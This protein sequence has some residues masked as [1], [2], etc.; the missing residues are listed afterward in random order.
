MG[1]VERLRGD[2]CD[3]GILR[4]F[5]WPHGNGFEGWAAVVKGVFFLKIGEMFFDICGIPVR[6]SRGISR[7][8][9]IQRMTYALCI[10]FHILQ[11][12][13]CWI[14]D[15]SFECICYGFNYLKGMDLCL[16]RQHTD[17]YDA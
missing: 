17:P 3:V 16:K 6:V 11:D 10:S 8:R 4:G 9:A 5:P 14:G 15:P 7:C 13:E 12:F 2:A 1:F